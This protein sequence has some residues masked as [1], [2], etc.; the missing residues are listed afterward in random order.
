MIIEFKFKP[1]KIINMTSLTFPN[2]PMFPKIRIYLTNWNQ[3]Q[4]EEEE[5]S[6]NSIKS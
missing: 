2:L 3:S 6:E 5:E 1:L 4:E